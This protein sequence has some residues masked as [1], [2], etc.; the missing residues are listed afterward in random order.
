LYFGWINLHACPANH[1][2]QEL[3]LRLVELTLGQL[4]VQLVFAQPAQYL[5]QM[6][7]VLLGRATV[8]QD[9]I[10]VNHHG[11]PDK[12]CVSHEQRLKSKT[13]R[14]APW[15]LKVPATVLM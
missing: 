2:P 3:Q 14:K 10:Q 5:T 9:V 7:L 4:N 13:R 11:F 12:G 8:H 6:H 1:M 15:A